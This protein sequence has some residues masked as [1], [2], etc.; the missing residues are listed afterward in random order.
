VL[1]G[2]GAKGVGGFV[3]CSTGSIFQGKVVAGFS[4]MIRGNWALM[5]L[6]AVLLYTNSIGGFLHFA[7]FGVVAITLTVM[8]LGGWSPR[9]ILSNPTLAV[10]KN[11]YIC[12][13]AS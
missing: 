11:K 5:V 7:E 2:N 13:K 6:C 9:Q 12:T 3:R 4:S 10:A 1:I 8:A